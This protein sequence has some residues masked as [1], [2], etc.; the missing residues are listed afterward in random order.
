[1]AYKQHMVCCCSLSWLPVN[2]KLY[3]YMTT[4]SRRDFLKLGVLSFLGTAF[5]SLTPP[6]GASRE[7]PIL[8]QG[9]S[10]YPRVALTYDDCNLI[11]QLRKLEIIY[12]QYPE[13]RITFFPV[14]EAMLNNEY[15]DPGIWRRFY[16]RGYEFGYHTF[17][18]E[19]INPQV[20]SAAKVIEDYQLWLEALREVL[21]TDPVVRFARPPFGNA[22]PSFLTMCAVFGLTPTIWSTGW[23]GPT[24]NVV[25]YTVPK[26]QNGDIVLMHTRI[27][28]VETTAL[29]LPQ[30]Q[31]RGI[32]AVT[33]SQ[34]YLDLL[35]EQNQSAG[36]G[37]FAAKSLQMTCIE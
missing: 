12:E 37:P 4:L 8:Y 30:V 23:G 3:T 20:L 11:T 5:G 36:C 34:L 28:D 14:G 1:M 27:E 35:K 2:A 18:L 26:L 17:P 9:S 33:M 13:M 24:E 25:Q 21:K 31:A 19:H 6:A 29:A 15:K 32:Q 7:Q 16:E 10:T 22:S